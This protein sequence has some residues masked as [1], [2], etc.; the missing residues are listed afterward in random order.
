MPEDEA[1]VL[2]LAEMQVME[3]LP[4]LDFDL[5]TTRATFLSAVEHASPTL[6]VVEEARKVIGYAMCLLENY[7][8]AAGRFVVLEAI[9]VRPDRRGTRAAASLVTRFFEW[10]KTVGAKESILGIANGF[11]PERTA[12]FFEHLGAQRVGMYLKR[13]N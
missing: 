8:F 4:H 5:A 1:A 11:Q 7:A 10:G 6:F 13:I 9:Y 12:R 2:G 3:T